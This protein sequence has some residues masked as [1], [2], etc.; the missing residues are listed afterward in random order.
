M[1]LT[2]EKKV[3]N[4]GLT[5][6]TTYKIKDK[7]NSNC[8]DT[9]SVFDS[10]CSKAFSQKLTYTGNGDKCT[11]Y[12]ANNVSFKKTDVLCYTIRNWKI[13][14]Y[15]CGNTYGF[16]STGTDIAEFSCSDLASAGIQQG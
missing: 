6:L 11:L 1:V 13:E 15:V 16:N 4:I 5:N 10:G 3:T 8:W 7:N 12:D 9:T 14:S 2:V